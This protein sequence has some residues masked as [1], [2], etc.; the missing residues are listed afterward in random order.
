MFI[1]IFEG[2]VISLSV[3]ISDITASFI[4]CLIVFKY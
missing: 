4:H 1:K 3:L 2:M